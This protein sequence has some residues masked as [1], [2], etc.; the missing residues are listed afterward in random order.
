MKDYNLFL[1]DVRVP[2]LTDMELKQIPDGYKHM[3]SAYYYTDFE[4]FKTEKWEVVTTY[5]EFVSFIEKNGCPSFV[6]FDHDLADE[7]YNYELD[8]NTYKEKTGYDA[9]KWL[10]EYCQDNHIK[11]P[12]YVVHSMNLVGTE[13]ITKYIEN[14][15]KYIEN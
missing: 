4:P 10:C 2:Y 3:A 14:Y 7:H 8:T 6:A 1:D 12:K 9:A 13:N 5:D 11:F 15:K